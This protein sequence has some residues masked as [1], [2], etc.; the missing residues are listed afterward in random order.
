MR[1][2]LAK[3]YCYRTHAFVTMIQVEI[4]PDILIVCA[5]PRHFTEY[6]ARTYTLPSLALVFG[7]SV[8]AALAI[9]A[10]DVRLSLVRVSDSASSSDANEQQQQQQQQQQEELTVCVPYKRRLLPLH[11]KLPD[12]WCGTSRQHV[13]QAHQVLA[14]ARRCF[15]DDPDARAFIFSP[16]KGRNESPNHSPPV[17]LEP[18]NSTNFQVTLRFPLA[19][20]STLSEPIV[21]ESFSMKSKK[22]SGVRRTLGSD[23]SQRRVPRTHSA[24]SDRDSALDLQ[25]LTVHENRFSPYSWTPPY[26][27]SSDDHPERFGEEPLMLE[28]ALQSLLS[29]PWE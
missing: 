12:N 16:T 28:S 27:D 3:L 22:R 13:H 20:G 17:S 10:L 8:S 9:N 23:R 26:D 7:G 14:H 18:P 29:P 1:A 21:L 6:R 15:A 25:T 19:N 24:R 2:S 4:A 11:A 5:M